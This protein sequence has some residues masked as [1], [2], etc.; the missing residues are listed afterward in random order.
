MS[1]GI[2]DNKQDKNDSQ[3]DLARMKANVERSILYWKPNAKRFHDFQKF[4]FKTGL[5]A[6]DKSSLNAA[7]KPILEFN[8]VNAPVSRQCGEFSKQEPSIEV[9][10]CAGKPIQPEIIEFIDGHLRYIFD[11]A[12]KRNVQYGSYRNSISGGFSHLKYWTEYENEMSFDQIIKVGKPY[13]DTM[14]GFDP[15]SKEIDKSDAEFYFEL[16]PMDKEQ[17]KKEHPKV[18]IDSLK[19]VKSDGLFNWSFRNQEQ[20]VVII[21]D[22]YQKVKTKKKIVLLANNETMLKDEYEKEV[23]KW[24][25]AG[26]AAQPPAVIEEDERDFIHIRRKRFIESSILEEKDTLYKINNI[27][28][29][30]GD[31]VIIQD[32]DNANMEQ[33]TKPY[34]YHTEGLQR[35]INFTGQV[36]GND[37]ESM[38]QH[39]FMIAEEA[40]P[41]QEEAQE[42]WTNSQQAQLLVHKYYSDINPDQTLPIPQAVPRV[43]LPPEVVQTF[44]GGIQMLQNILG[45]YDLSQNRQQISGD[46]IE[47]AALMSNGAVAPYI[48]NYMQSLTTLANGIVDLIPKIN[49]RKRELP[50]IL[51]DG[52]KKNVKVN[53]EGGI[54]LNY[55]SNHIQVNVQAG[56]NFSVA[57][58][59]ALQQLTMLMKVS[60][61]FSEFMMDVGLETLLDNVEFRNSDIVRAKVKAWQ[62]KKA[63]M[64][65]QQ[66]DPE[67]IKAK[68]MEQQAANEAKQ[69]QLAETK[70]QLEGEQISSKAT[71]ETE[72]LLIDKEKVD[73]ER[74]NIMQKAGESQDKLEVGFAKAEAEEVRARADLGMKAHH[75]D[76]TQ[77]K[78]LGE[79]VIK[80]HEATKPEHKKEVKE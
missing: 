71:L 67:V 49:K 62:Q 50:V 38:V 44:N 5:S 36:I 1:Y 43:G 17:F 11:D 42:A 76:H 16:F 78:E 27:V 39:K 45:S 7:Q 65:K 58:N 26:N 55:E 8:I 57:K 51:K 69:L 40:L 48:V 80:H 31:S 63:E 59:K 28:Y 64:K 21:C 37:F 3:N 22:Y 29:V 61:E 10:A 73:N 46:A 53:Q 12:K 66:P 60:P 33:F 77:F 9:S 6:S 54:S 35:L 47:E 14:V 23:E 18:D 70:L 4:T 13:N 30:D 75:Q 32:E 56:V 25:A 79:L 72:K 52:T 24:N 68:A 2:V 19:F 20:Y 34:I 41:T 15:M 74:L